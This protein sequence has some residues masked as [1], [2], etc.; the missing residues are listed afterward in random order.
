MVGC[1]II[2]AAKMI[3][4]TLAVPEYQIS[5]VYSLTLVDTTK[6]NDVHISDYLIE[7]GFAVACEEEQNA[8][9]AATPVVEYP[10]PMPKLSPRPS[11]AFPSSSTSS[12]ANQF[13]NTSLSSEAASPAVSSR[14]FDFSSPSIDDL[15]V[16][17]TNPSKTHTSQ[18]EDLLFVEQSPSIAP[19]SVSPER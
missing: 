1:K 17:D 14:Q 12:L 13:E 2:A 18:K 8:L 15:F 11:C 5:T 3:E 6:E 19:V 16:Y 4:E 9:V 7:N 10:D